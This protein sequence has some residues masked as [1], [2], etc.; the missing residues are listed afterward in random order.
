MPGT[1]LQLLRRDNSGVIYADPAKP[2][3]TA[4]FRNSTS[5]KTLNGVP[6]KN[7]L[8]EIIV[9]EDFQVTLGSV[10]ATDAISVRIRVSGCAESM[11]EIG[12]ILHALAGQIDT[13]ASEHVFTGFDPTTAPVIPAAT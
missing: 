11:T 7:Y 3:L 6:V 1:T 2:E 9:N 12:V 5:Q 8:T 10:S 4:R 13:W